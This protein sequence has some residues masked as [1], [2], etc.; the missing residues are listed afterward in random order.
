MRSADLTTHTIMAP[1][2]QKKELGKAYAGA[3]FGIR[4]HHPCIAHWT[5]QQVYWQGEIHLQLILFNL[6]TPNKLST[7]YELGPVHLFQIVSFFCISKESNSF[8]RLRG[9]GT[10]LA[11][12][13]P[14]LLRHPLSGYLSLLL[15]RA[16]TVSLHFPVSVVGWSKSLPNRLSE[17]QDMTQPWKCIVDISVSQNGLKEN[18][19]E[20]T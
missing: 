3:F 9:V 17:S 4:V 6:H 8:H 5:S 14:C 7:L 11:I 19:A 1:L 16:F 12:S 15:V 20:L 13:L 10:V 18:V 2:E